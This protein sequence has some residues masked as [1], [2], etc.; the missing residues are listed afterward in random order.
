MSYFGVF[1]E[2]G[3]APNDGTAIFVTPTPRDTQDLAMNDFNQIP[4]PYPDVYLVEADSREAVIS[5][6][7]EAELSSL[8]HVKL[9]R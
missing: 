4:M 2:P 5:A 9:L 7:R 8:R 1:I 3:K 6:F